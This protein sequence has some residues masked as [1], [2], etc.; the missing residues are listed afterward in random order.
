MSDHGIDVKRAIED[1]LGLADRT[2]A[3]PSGDVM[4]HPDEILAIVELLTAKRPAGCGC[5]V[6][7]DRDG[8]THIISNPCGIHGAQRPDDFY[9][10]GF[11][12]GYRGGPGIDPDTLNSEE[13]SDWDAGY[14]A[15]LCAAEPDSDEDVRVLR[16]R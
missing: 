3:F 7:D 1:L 5:L 12:A 16:P 4:V 2:P 6:V 11:W 8:G 9:G 15:G 14:S 13:R 10:D